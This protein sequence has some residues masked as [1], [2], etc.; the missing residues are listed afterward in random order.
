MPATKSDA[1]SRFLHFTP[2][3][4]SA[5]A[6]LALLFTSACGDSQDSITDAPL[7][8]DEA[9]PLLDNGERVK[10]QLQPGLV[11]TLEL[12]PTRLH[13]GSRLHVRSV[14]RNESNVRQ[15]A[16]ALVCQLEIRTNMEF[17]SIEPLILCFAYSISTVLEPR[18][19]LVLTAEGV[20]KS[21]PGTYAMAVRHLLRPDIVAK[22]RVRVY[23]RNSDLTTRPTG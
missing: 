9:A 13:T 17:E 4:F 23:P 21:P 2:L 12:T 11:Q 19:S 14:V 10:V 16:E 8:V 22:V 20:V 18:D 3:L 7:A 6:A 1:Y 5:T 15:K